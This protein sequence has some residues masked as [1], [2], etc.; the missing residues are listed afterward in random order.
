MKKHNY[1]SPQL[2]VLTM[3]TLQTIM[4]ASTQDE[5]PAIGSEDLD[6]DFEHP[7]PGNPEDAF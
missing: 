4:V 7:T 6:I 3:V 2:K 5:V 1:S